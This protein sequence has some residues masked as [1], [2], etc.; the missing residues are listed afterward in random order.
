[1]KAYKSPA[2]LFRAAFGLEMPVDAQVSF[3]VP[4]FVK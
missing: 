1:M 2:K 3:F 4:I